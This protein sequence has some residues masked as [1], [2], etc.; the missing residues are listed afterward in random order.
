VVMGGEECLEGL[1]GFAGFR[2]FAC[3]RGSA[4][5][6]AIQPVLSILLVLELFYSK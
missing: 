5:A 1:E 4:C 6:A 2:G 3:F